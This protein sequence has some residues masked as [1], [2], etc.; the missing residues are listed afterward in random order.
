MNI[1]DQDNGNIRLKLPQ[2]I[3]SI[4]NGVDLPKNMAPRHKPALSIN[5]LL[6]D[7]TTPPFDAHF[8]YRAVVGKLN[9]LEKSTRAD[10][11]YA[12]NKCT[13][14]SQDP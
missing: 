5:I 3:Y 1:E 7:T 4:I 11:T 8:S 2:M 12:M 13:L 9:L 10:I 6:R 14:F